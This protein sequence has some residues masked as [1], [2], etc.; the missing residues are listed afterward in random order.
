MTDGM[1]TR[2]Y[3]NL[4]LDSIATAEGQC[5]TMVPQ[6]TV[7]GGCICV[8]DLVYERT[9]NHIYAWVDVINQWQNGTF[10]IGNI[11]GKNPNGSG[12]FW[13]VLDSTQ[14]NSTGPINYMVA[15]AGSYHLH[16]QANINTTP[17]NMLPA[18]TLIFDLMVNVRTTLHKDERTNGTQIGA[19][20]LLSGQGFYHY[21]G[22]DT[23]P[24]YIDDYGGAESSV[25]LVKKVGTLWYQNHANQPFGVGDISRQNGGQFLN[26]I[27]GLPDHA[28]HWNGLDVDVR[29]VGK[30]NYVGPLDLA[31]TNQLTNVYDRTKTIELMNLFATNASL[32]RIIV[33]PNAGISSAD[34]PGATIVIDDVQ[35]KH[36][37]HFHVSLND[38]DGPN[39]NNCD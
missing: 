23:A 5:Q 12:A 16:F 13:H 28:E 2:P 34:V 19:V 30:D 26:A 14:P 4:R 33:D 1:F 35:R 8:P 24:N 17:C 20:R 36:H 27:T 7:G 3:T 39:S 9:V 18:T 29:Y 11:F 31:N 15:S 21:W 32:Y 22:D 38:P 6:C 25:G 10:N 37:H